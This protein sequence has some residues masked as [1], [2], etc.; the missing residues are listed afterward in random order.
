M[1]LEMYIFLGLFVNCSFIVYSKIFKKKYELIYVAD[2]QMW[3]I[4]PFHLFL[5]LL[6]KKKKKE[7]IQA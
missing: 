5:H 4:I 3:L 7:N 1:K 2:E 6:K